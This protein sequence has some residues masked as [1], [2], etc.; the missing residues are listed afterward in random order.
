[1]AKR[2]G[3]DGRSSAGARSNC[4]WT[5]SCSA[6]PRQPRRLA[7]R[8]DGSLTGVFRRRT[9]CRPT[10]VRRVNVFSFLVRPSRTCCTFPLSDGEQATGRPEACRH[11]RGGYGWGSLV[12]T[13]VDTPVDDRSADTVHQTLVRQLAGRRGRVGAEGGTAVGPLVSNGHVNDVAAVG[14]QPGNVRG[15]DREGAR[16]RRHR[17]ASQSNSIPTLPR[18]RPGGPLRA[19]SPVLRSAR[20]HSAQ[21]VGSAKYCVGARLAALA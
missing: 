21:A 18:G 5:N 6:D 17:S 9:R 10:R 16:P 20:T 2:S 3:G 12:G 7:Q 13:P 11:S 1:M 8:N 4:S 14:G 19:R 15:A